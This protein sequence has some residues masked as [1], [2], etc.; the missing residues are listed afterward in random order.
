MPMARTTQSQVVLVSPQGE[1]LIRKTPGICGGEACIRQTRIMV[2][3]LV[4]LK[5]EG[6]TEAELLDNYPG[7]TA[8]DLAAAWEYHRLHL[9][10]VEKAIEVNRRDDECHVS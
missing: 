10:E 8:D 1:P 6:M 7:L 4:E 9:E 2:W 3:L 5:R